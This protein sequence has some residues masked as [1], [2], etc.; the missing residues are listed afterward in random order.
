[1][2]IPTRQMGKLMELILRQHYCEFNRKLYIQTDV[3]A[4]GT[5]FAPF[6]ANLFMGRFE[7]KH[8]EN[9]TI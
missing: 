6:F 1:M 8:I 3:T 2:E 7:S 5:R 4:I 9:Y